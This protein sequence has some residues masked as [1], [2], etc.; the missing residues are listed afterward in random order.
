MNIQFGTIIGLNKTTEICEWCLE[1]G[2][3][4]FNSQSGP[5]L[6]LETMLNIMPIY[7]DHEKSGDCV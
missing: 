3:Q 2:G 1:K 5:L 7:H 6:T 4:G